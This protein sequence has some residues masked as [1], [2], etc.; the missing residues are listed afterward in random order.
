MT[1][2]IPAFVATRRRFEAISDL[3]WRTNRTVTSEETGEAESPLMRVKLR[4]CLIAVDGRRQG[5]SYRDLA[6][7]LFGVERVASEW[8]GPS[9]FLKERTR[10][11]V[12]R[13]VGLVDGRYRDLLG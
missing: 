5:L 8:N 12:D 9:R 2:Q 13:G 6:K 1:F 10:R 4:Q 7:V 11:L 3:E